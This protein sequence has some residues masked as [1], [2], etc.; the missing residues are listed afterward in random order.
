MVAM[1][2][3]ADRSVSVSMILS[4]IERRDARGQFFQADLLNKRSYRLTYMT[5]ITHAGRGV[6]VGVAGPQ[7]FSV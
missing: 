4:D 3:V 1:K 2:R 6:F 7:S 5:S